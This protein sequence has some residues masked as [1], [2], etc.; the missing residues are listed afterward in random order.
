MR[1]NQVI[2]IEGEAEYTLVLDG[3]EHAL[4]GASAPQ[5]AD[6]LRNQVTRER[7]RDGEFRS[8]H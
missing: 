7:W 6:R 8:V 3:D 4:A 5:D 1:R 2:V